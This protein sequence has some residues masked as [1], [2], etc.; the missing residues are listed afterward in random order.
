ME[1]KEALNTFNG[2]TNQAYEFLKM[3]GIAV[4]RKKS[5]G[6]TWAKQDYIDWIKANIPE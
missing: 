2:S 1:C 5:N 6:S 3:I 4:C